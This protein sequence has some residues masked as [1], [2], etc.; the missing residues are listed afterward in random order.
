MANQ[1]TYGETAGSRMEVL[2]NLSPC[3]AGVVYGECPSC[4]MNE[5]HGVWTFSKSRLLKFELAHV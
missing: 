4:W 1:Y 3:R 2:V 5:E